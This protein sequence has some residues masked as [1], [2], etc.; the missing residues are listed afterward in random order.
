MVGHAPQVWKTFLALLHLLDLKSQ[1]NVQSEPAHKPASALGN[2]L[3][4]GVM[5]DFPASLDFRVLQIYYMREMRNENKQ[6][7]IFRSTREGSR[8]Q[9]VFTQK[10][11][12]ILLY[13]A[14]THG[15]HSPPKPSQKMAYTPGSSGS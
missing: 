8:R 12:L 13:R 3:L 2:G 10:G 9:V 4:L 7:L 14:G 6:S 1:T 11:Q 15:Q 5:N